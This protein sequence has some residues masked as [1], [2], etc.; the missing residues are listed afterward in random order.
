MKSRLAGGF[1]SINAFTID[2]GIV[3]DPYSKGVRCGVHRT[4]CRQLRTEYWR[5]LFALRPGAKPGERFLGGLQLRP[6]F[7]VGIPGL[8]PG[9]AGLSFGPP[10]GLCLVLIE[11]HRV[12]IVGDLVDSARA[13]VGDDL[14]FDILHHLLR[15]GI[16]RISVAGPPG[17]EA[18]GYNSTLGD[19]RERAE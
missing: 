16:E 18:E 1:P 19:R 17:S 15:V 14:R 13:P 3:S 11:T 5:Q 6:L 9:Q 7:Y 10:Q 4:P 8:A 12:R 2:L